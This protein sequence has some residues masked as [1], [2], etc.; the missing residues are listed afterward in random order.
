[1]T[2]RLA[3]GTGIDQEASKPEVASDARLG[4]DYCILHLRNTLLE[5]SAAKVALK[6]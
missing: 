3:Q 1:M 2:R 6:D 5:G 4:A